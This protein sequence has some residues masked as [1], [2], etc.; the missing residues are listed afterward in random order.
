MNTVIRHIGEDKDDDNKGQDKDEDTVPD[1]DEDKARDQ[2]EG[3][4]AVLNKDNGN[5]EDI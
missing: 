3:K 2:D 4:Y 1:E 5:D